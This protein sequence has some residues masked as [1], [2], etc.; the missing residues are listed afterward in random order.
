LKL[1]RVFGKEYGYACEKSIVFTNPDAK[2]IECIK[3]LIE[4]RRSEIKEGKAKKHKYVPV[5]DR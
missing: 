3:T 5:K 1:S 4:L 2:A